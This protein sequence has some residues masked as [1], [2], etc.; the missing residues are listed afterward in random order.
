MDEHDFF[1]AAHL[2]LKQVHGVDD[3][4]VADGF[5]RTIVNQ[6]GRLQGIHAVTVDLGGDR[7]GQLGVGLAHRVAVAGQHGLVGQADALH[8]LFDGGLAGGGGHFFNS[9]L[10]ALGHVGGIANVGVG[11]H[12]DGIAG[13]ALQRIV[14]FGKRCH[15]QL[16]RDARG[17]HISHNLRVDQ[18]GQLRDEIRHIV[19][20]FLCFYFR[21]GGQDAAPHFLNSL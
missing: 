18:F 11:G 7:Q 6:A 21:R 16:L 3:G 5:C 12:G 19:S 2:I 10:A 8:G 1:A 9:Y 15:A 17:H 20:P 14:N 4:I 13:H